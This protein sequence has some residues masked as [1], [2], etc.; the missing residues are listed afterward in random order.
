MD[1]DEAMLLDFVRHNDRI[2]N[3]TAQQLLDVDHGRASYLLKKLHKEGKLSK[4]GERRWSYYVL[5]EA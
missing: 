5:P 4:Q 1:N 3:A 2:N